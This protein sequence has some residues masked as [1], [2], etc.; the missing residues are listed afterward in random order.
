MDQVRALRP[1]L[2]L[3]L[4][5]LIALCV[6]ASP[7]A[8]T[9]ISEKRAKAREIQARLEKVYPQVDMAVER[10]N[11][12]MERLGTVDQQIKQNEH[13]LRVAKFNLEAAKAQLEARAVSMYKTR[14]V[15][16]VDVLFSTSSFDELVTQLDMMQRLGA[17]DV[18][19][20]KQIA[21]YKRDIEERHSQLEADRQTAARLLEE[22]KQQKQ[23]IQALQAKLQ[24]ME[25]GVKA[26]IRRLQAAAARAAER[27][28]ARAAAQAAAPGGRGLFEQR[29]RRRLTAGT[30]RPRRA[31]VIRRSSGHR[32]EGARRSIRLGRRRPERVRLLRP[33]HVLLRTDRHRADPRRD[34]PVPRQQTGT[35]QRAVAR[36]PGLLRLAQLLLP[37]R[38]L[39]RGRPDDRRAP[40]RRRGELRLHQRRLLR[41]ALLAIRP[42]REAPS[43]VPLP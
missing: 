42:S 10:Y 33:H 5:A 41:R 7:A 26:E 37:R 19:I 16:I 24:R 25:A 36:R 1:A 43:S 8:A 2:I 30:R 9:R 34:V 4:A 11:Q 38:Y 3:I 20:V 6:T 39:C 40:H 31:Q 23:K 17:S 14:D 35:A 27:A 15:G 22:A 18:S 32:P 13:Q 12:A 29:K 28:A 21:A